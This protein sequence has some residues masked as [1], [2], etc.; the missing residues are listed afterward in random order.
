MK[1]QLK[2]KQLS[3]MLKLRQTGSTSL[4]FLPLQF[5]KRKR[6]ALSKK[7]VTSCFSI[8]KVE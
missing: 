3:D 8:N 1:L 4:L 7:K 5:Y 6:I 2:E